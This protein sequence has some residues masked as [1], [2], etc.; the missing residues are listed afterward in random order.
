MYVNHLCINTYKKDTYKK[1][2]QRMYIIINSVVTEN[3]S[4]LAIDVEEKG[5]TYKVINKVYKDSIYQHDRL[6]HLDVIFL[7]K[8]TRNLFMNKQ[9]AI[10]ELLIM[11]DHSIHRLENTVKELY[12]YKEL[13]VHEKL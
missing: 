3:I 7:K 8:D 11:L 5:K 1:M 2:V 9:E 13:I 4:I 12:A 6:P 10:D